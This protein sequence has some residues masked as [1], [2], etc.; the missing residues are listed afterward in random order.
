MRQKPRFFRAVWGAFFARVDSG[1]L[2]A[3]LLCLFALLPLLRPGLP[4]GT[5]VLYHVYRVAEMDRAWA[6]GLL[7]PRWAE[8]FYYGYGSPVFHYYAS[9][10]YYLTSVLMRLLALD[11]LNALRA[12]IAVCVLLG[13]AGMYL[14]ARVVWRHRAAG[15]IAALCFVYAPYMLFTEPYARG[16]YPETLALALLPLALWRFYVVLR[17]GRGLLLAAPLVALLILTHNLM[18]LA[19]FGLLAAWLLWH[20]LTRAA[21]WRN[22]ALAGAALAF[23]VGLAGYFWLPVILERGEVKLE[24]LIAVAQLDFRNFFVPLAQLAAFSPRP[25]NGA[26]NGLLHQ[27]NMGVAQWGLALAA[28][29]GAP[30]GVRETA[31]PAQSRLR[32]F[33]ALLSTPLWSNLLFFAFASL[34]LIF[35]SAPLSASLWQNISALAY[36]Q[37]PWRFLGPLAVTLALLAGANALWL[38]RLPAA[39]RRA[40]LGLALLLPLGLA[41]PTLYVPEWV[42]PQVDASIAAYQQAEV[43]GLQLGTTFSNEYLPQSVFVLAGPTPRL[44]ADMADGYPVNR[45]HLEALPPGVQLELLEHGPQHD[46]W[47]V[48]A[49]EPF[50][51]EVLTLYFAG[52]QAQI[53]GENVPVTPSDP[54]GFITIPVPAGEHTVRLFL[55]STPAR[56]L[57]GWL[58]LLAAGALVALAR[59]VRRVTRALPEK[60]QDAREN[61]WWAGAAAGALMLALA[62]F[63]LREGGAWVQSPPGT[64]LPAQ[65]RVDYRLGENTYLIGYDLNATSFRPGARVE[66]VLYWY[67]AQP[68]PYKYQPFVHIGVPGVPP[69]AQAPGK[70]HPGG[71]PM[72]EWTPAGY[73]RDEHIIFLPETMPPGRYQIIIG[74]YTCETRPAGAC[75]NGERPPV[76]AADGA[77]LGD[78]LP[79]ATISVGS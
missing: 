48:S 71:R 31:P 54:H 79:L 35:I 36:F 11:A 77:P 70:D 19:S 62:F 1:L 78:A 18:A 15:V 55:G 39:A 25:D 10:T 50:T 37:F 52:W 21:G 56:G 27:L 12:L 34:G 46:T 53:D 24:N 76:Y 49:A 66:L 16:A 65:N 42:H 6:H 41:L 13:G 40:L 68:A 4:N 57:G 9:F 45:A 5:D 58:T 30:F 43:S 8:N 26:L 14:L 7:L 69:L 47:R 33:C 32:A 29:L 59:R 51:L 20:A 64:A 38:A 74:L 73:I 17:D 3:L 67:G 60:W 72:T 44:L 63:L 22:L 2:L 61:L 23:G 28:L 75:G